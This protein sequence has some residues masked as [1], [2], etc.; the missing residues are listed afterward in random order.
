MKAQISEL[1]ETGINIISVAGGYEDED[2]NVYSDDEI[3]SFADLRKCENVLVDKKEK[4]APC[5]EVLIDDEIVCVQFRT[6]SHPTGFGK[7]RICEIA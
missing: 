4:G 1:W 5:T 7:V 3:T 6:V 2:G